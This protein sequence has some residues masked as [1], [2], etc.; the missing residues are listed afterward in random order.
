MN[1]FDSNAIPEDVAAA[2]KKIK[3]TKDGAIEVEMHAKAPALEAIGKSLGL[4]QDKGEAAKTD[5]VPEMST[6]EIARRIAFV[7]RAAQE[8]MQ[9]AE[10]SQ[11]GRD[12]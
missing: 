2:I 9:D 8:E 6:L 7:L 10:K 5:S 1:F 11:N 4:W 3:Q 12:G